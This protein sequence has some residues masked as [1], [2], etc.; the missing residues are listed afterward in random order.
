LTL[1]FGCKGHEWDYLYK[2]E[3]NAHHGAGLL[4]ELHCA[5][6]RDQA[7][8]VYVQDLILKNKDKVCQALFDL[9]GLFYMCG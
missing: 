5:F 9:N 2:E 1:Y 8:K 4:K 3:F 6:S 7:E